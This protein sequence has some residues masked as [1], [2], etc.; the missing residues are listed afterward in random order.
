MHKDA[1]L[2]MILF[3]KSTFDILLSHKIILQQN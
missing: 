3:F 1:Y 2:Q